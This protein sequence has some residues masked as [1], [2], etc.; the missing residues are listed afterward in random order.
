LLR[1]RV[2]YTTPEWA[3]SITGIAADTIRRIAAEMAQTARDH[4]ITL[5]IPW[6]D[7]WGVKHETV[8]GNPVA[9][10]A[11]RGLAAHS[12]GFQSIRALAVLM[13]LLGTIDRPGG[14]RHKSPYPRAVPPSAKPP[15]SPHDVKPNTPLP[16]GPLGWP[17]APGDLFIDEAGEPVRIDKAF[18]WE[19]PLAVHGTSSRTRGAAIRTRSTHC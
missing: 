14:F 7:S 10:H 6:T 1:K 12:N 13:S 11:M 5:P 16:A 19:Y 15:N 4:K 9:F 8:T 3:E 17:A 2:A 18:S